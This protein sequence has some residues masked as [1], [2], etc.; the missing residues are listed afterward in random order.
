MGAEEPARGLEGGCEGPYLGAAEGQLQDAQG[1]PGWQWDEEHRAGA[2]SGHAGCR[3]RDAGAPVLPRSLAAALLSSPGFIRGCV[4]VC[5]LFFPWP[6][7]SRRKVSPW[8]RLSL[9]SLHIRGF[10][11][12]HVTGPADAGARRWLSRHSPWCRAPTTAS[13]GSGG[14]WH[15]GVQEEANP[16]PLVSVGK[17]PG[18]RDGF[19][20][21]AGVRLAAGDGAAEE[22]SLAAPRTHRPRHGS[23]GVSSATAGA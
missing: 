12:F 17:S 7:P 5:L 20:F 19:G 9:P 1:Q 11:A 3:G 6:R 23:A 16:V 8:H 18:R 4:P 10:G 22:G 15:T 2:G 13:H 14:P 21:G